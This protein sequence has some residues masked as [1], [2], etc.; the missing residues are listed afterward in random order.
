[1]RSTSRIRQFDLG[2]CGPP[3]QPKSHCTDDRDHT[4]GVIRS[5]VLKREYKQ[6]RGNLLSTAPGI[7]SPV[8]ILLCR[9]NARGTPIRYNSTSRL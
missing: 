1:M 9:E 6:L 8:S 2:G 5:F 7:R 4:S 3:Q